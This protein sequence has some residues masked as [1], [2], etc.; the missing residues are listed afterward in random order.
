MEKAV[1]LDRDVVIV[2]D[3]GYLHQISEVRFLPKVRE[4]IKLLNS[5][6]LCRCGFV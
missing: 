2:E 1:F 5:A 3:T 6:R 4:A